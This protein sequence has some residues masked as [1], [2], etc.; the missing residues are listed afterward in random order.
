MKVVEIDIFG[1]HNIGLLG[2]SN[3]KVAIVGNFLNK[4][5]IE[6]LRVL[7]VDVEKVVIS[8]TDLIGIFSALNSNGLLLPRILLQSERERFKKLTK[9]LGMNMKVLNSKFTALGNLIL[10]NDHGAI[11]SKLFSKRDRKVIADCLDVPV[12]TGR[13]AGIDVIGSAAVATNGGCL[14]H[15]DSSEEEIEFVEDVLK[16]ETD[17]GTA[18]FGSPFVGSCMIA[19][20][21]GAVVGRSTTGPELVRITEALNLL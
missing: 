4:S 7:R 11:V 1:D 19:N 9:E 18:N 17:I 20:R 13:I 21:N 10:S 2:K 5:H 15:R 14:L 8:Y 6:Q 3:D 16:V 12:E